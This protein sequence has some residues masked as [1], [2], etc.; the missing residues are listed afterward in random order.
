MGEEPIMLPEAAEAV[1]IA[2]EHLAGESVERRKALAADIQQA[3]MR[4]AG[5]IAEAAISKT[6]ASL[7][8]QKH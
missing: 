1:K 2:D 3:I 7:N 4:H 5:G 8:H 6:F